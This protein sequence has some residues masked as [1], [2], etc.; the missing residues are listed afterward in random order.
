MMLFTLAGR[1]GS[2]SLRY[3]VVED[4]TCFWIVVSLEY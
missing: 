2:L 3:G 4:L 1:L